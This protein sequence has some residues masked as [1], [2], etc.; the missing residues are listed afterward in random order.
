LVAEFT[1]LDDE[2]SI[3]VQITTLDD[4]VSDGKILYRPPSPDFY[5]TDYFT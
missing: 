2:G 1:L 4:Y 3:D 5:N